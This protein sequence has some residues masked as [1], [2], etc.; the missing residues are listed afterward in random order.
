MTLARK[1]PPIALAEGAGVARYLDHLSWESGPGPGGKLLRELSRVIWGSVLQRAKFKAAKKQQMI[2]FLER[3]AD[4]HLVRFDVA[5]AIEIVQ[6]SPPPKDVHP[7]PILRAPFM[8]VTMGPGSRRLATDISERICAG[9]WALCFAGI[10]RAGWHVAEAL[11]RHRI[12]GR[13]GKEA[14]WSSCEVAERVKEYEKHGLIKP[15]GDRKAGR[16]WLVKKWNTLYSP[17]QAWEKP[18]GPA[19]R[20]S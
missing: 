16:Q 7:L 19:G 17:N 3:V 6:S 8:T 13:G 5:A 15:E 4:T 14:S 18:P 2:A 12:P 1:V 11:N 10:A 20:R 9:Y